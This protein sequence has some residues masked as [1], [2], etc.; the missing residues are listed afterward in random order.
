MKLQT[1]IRKVC[2][3]PYDL[4]VAAGMLTHGHSVPQASDLMP[5]L[6]DFKLHHYQKSYNIY[7][8]IPLSVFRTNF[9]G[10]SCRLILSVFIFRTSH[11]MHSEGWLT[12]IWWRAVGGVREDLTKKL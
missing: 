5:A 11:V 9:S 10:V 3:L 4:A 7:Y 1:L 2:P 12:R 8:L 6:W